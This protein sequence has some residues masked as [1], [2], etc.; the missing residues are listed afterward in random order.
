MIPPK[1]PL[2]LV[3]WF[4]GAEECTRMN[5]PAHSQPGHNRRSLH[6]LWTLKIPFCVFFEYENLVGK[7]N[8]D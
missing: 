3:S 6:M 2:H 8:R 1:S 7:R 4:S 5:V